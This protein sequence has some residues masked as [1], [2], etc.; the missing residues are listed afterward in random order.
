VDYEQLILTEIRDV[1]KAQGEQGREIGT[2]NT[3]LAV[4]ETSME[5]INSKLGDTKQTANGTADFTDDLD[6]RVE[7]L[8]GWCNAFKSRASR[9]GWALLAFMLTQAGTWIAWIVMGR[10]K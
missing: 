2:I 7:S 9:L 10:K 3:R 6:G 8:E 4:V 5:Q 1:R